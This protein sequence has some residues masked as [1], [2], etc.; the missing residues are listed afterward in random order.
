MRIAAL[1]AASLLV[2]GCSHTTGGH[3]QPSSSTT[4]TSTAAGAPGSRAP[5][6]TA[7][8]GAKA[9][10][11]DVITWIEAGHPADPGR[12]HTATRDGTAT[13]L[14]D[15]IALTAMGGK[16]SCMTDAKH[17]G[18]ALLCLVSLTNPPPAPATAYGQWHGGWIS[19]DGVN[20]QVGSARA[21]PGPFINGNG[22]ELA[23]GDSLSFGDYRCRADQAGL[24]CVNYAHQS[25]AKFGPA[26][27]EPFGCLKS[28]PPPDG[29][30]TAFSC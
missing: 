20:L 9:P 5:G 12:F 6:P 4:Q 1:L 29:V 27:I 17:T 25:A 21:D 18:N 28:T 8:P 2:A 22:P 15:D 19:F 24:Y 16:V 3:S 23:I 13:P 26:G 10:I 30:G 14:G 11:S 7:A